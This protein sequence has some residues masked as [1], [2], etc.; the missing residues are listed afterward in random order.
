MG[1]CCSVDDGDEDVGIVKNHCGYRWG[2]F[3]SERVYPRTM[4]FVEDPSVAHCTHQHGAVAL[5]ALS[6]SNS[7][8]YTLENR[9]VLFKIIRD[10][11]VLCPLRILMYKTRKLNMAPLVNSP[12]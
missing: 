6:E 11:R 7:G 4:K 12:Y 10:R 5:E 3:G 8:S 1:Q 2:L 9:R